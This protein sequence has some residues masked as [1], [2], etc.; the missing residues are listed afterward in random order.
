MQNSF[1]NNVKIPETC[2]FF[3]T[4]Y[5]YLVLIHAMAMSF[6]TVFYRLS[7]IGDEIALIWLN[8]PD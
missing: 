3:L 2:K 5:S 7:N 4:N 8:G 1:T 6:V